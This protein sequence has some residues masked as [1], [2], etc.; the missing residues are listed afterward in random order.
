MRAPKGESE[1]SSEFLPIKWGRETW[2]LA[3]GGPQ[4]NEELITTKSA[5]VS[6]YLYVSPTTAGP[7]IYMIPD[8]LYKFNTEN[9][10]ILW[11]HLWLLLK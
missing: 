7:H 11:Y 1:Q 2:E 6:V 10:L 8:P 3:I 4:E 5:L 9:Y